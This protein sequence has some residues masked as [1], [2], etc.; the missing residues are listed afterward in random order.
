MSELS[1]PYPFLITAL[2]ADVVIGYGVV[3]GVRVP[4]R[5]LGDSIPPFLASSIV[6]SCQARATMERPVADACYAIGNCYARKVRATS[7]HGRT[8]AGFLRDEI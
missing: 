4:I 2:I 8:D 6:Y 3:A 5:A 1:L 7:E